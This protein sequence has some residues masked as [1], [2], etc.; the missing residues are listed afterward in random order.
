MQSIEDH[1]SEYTGM[2]ALHCKLAEKEGYVLQKKKKRFTEMYNYI[3]RHLAKDFSVFSIGEAVLL[4]ASGDV[5]ET[6]HD[7]LEEM[8]EAYKWMISGV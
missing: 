7:T 2:I 3:D 5:G 8:L 6:A 4:S 1:R